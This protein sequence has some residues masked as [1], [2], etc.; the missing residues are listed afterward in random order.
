MPVLM[1]F[2]L[3]LPVCGVSAGTIRILVD[4]EHHSESETPEELQERRACVR[5]TTRTSQSTS[6]QLSPRL[7]SS[8]IA[9]WRRSAIGHRLTCEMLAPLRC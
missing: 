5:C 7:L 3:C 6:K 1:L 8:K 2:L 9:P 4:E